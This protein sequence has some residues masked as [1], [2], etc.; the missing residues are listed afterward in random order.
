M[1]ESK[2][3]E[4]AQKTGEV[5]ETVRQKFIDAD[6][7]F[8]DAA[9]VADMDPL[10]AMVGLISIHRSA[11]DKLDERIKDVVDRLKGGKFDPDEEA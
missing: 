2:A 10:S 4:I 11:A 3:K 8:W 1:N 5:F 9:E 7:A 6:L